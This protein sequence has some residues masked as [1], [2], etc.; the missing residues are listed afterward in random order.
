MI[1]NPKIS[2]T[3]SG[4]AGEYFVAAELSR[5]GYIASITLR[6]TRGVD[7]LATNTEATRAIGIQVKTNQGSDKDWI[8]SRKVETDVADNLLFVFVNLNG[9]GGIPTFHIVP[10]TIVAAYCTANH[11]A[12]LAAPSRSGKPHQ[13][14]AVRKF[15]DYDDA[16]LG[17]W[18]LLGL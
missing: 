16:Y 8:L 6:N 3:L 9:I 4:V 15:A 17:K 14:S 11:A 12:W 18:N 13:D 7:I 2:T 10:S 1:D 5:R